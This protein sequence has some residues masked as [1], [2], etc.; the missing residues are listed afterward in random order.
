MKDIIQ[1]FDDSPKMPSIF[2]LK[3]TKEKKSRKIFNSFTIFNARHWIYLTLLG[4]IS[5]IVIGIFDLLLINIT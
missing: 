2:V 4:V 1:N 3:T 5:A